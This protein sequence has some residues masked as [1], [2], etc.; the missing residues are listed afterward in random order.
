MLTPK[1]SC[2]TITNA[3]S[4]SFCHIIGKRK[5]RSMEMNKFRKTLVVI[6]SALFVLCMATFAACTT[7]DS[8]EKE[9]PEA[10]K[11]YL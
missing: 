7:S 3:Y 11:K 2:D 1:L 6:L 8:D 4:V 5:I 9:L 10:L